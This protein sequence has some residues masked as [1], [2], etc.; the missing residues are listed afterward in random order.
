MTGQLSLFGVEAAQP[1]PADL[2]GLLAGPGQVTRM[3]G[4]ARVA[5]VVAERWRALALLAEARARGLAA[6]ATARPDGSV[7]VRTAYAAVLAPLAARWLPSGAKDAPQPLRLDG[8]RLRLWMM[9]AGYHDGGSVRLYLGPGEERVW[10]A[11]RRALAGLGLS[12][13]LVGTDPTPE[14]AAAG[15][16]YRI[17]D[18]RRLARLAELVGEP[19]PSAPPGAWPRRP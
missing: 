11:V 9:A 18:R 16:A 4:T 15:P 19:P 3:G 10:V 14:D 8:L 17:T 2:E 1:A 12:A 7:D 13:E 6:S 5:I